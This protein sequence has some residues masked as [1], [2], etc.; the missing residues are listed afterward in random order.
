[1]LIFGK[2]GFVLAIIGLDPHGKRRNLI[3]RIITSVMLIIVIWLLLFLVILDPN[4]DIELVQAVMSPIVGFISTA[5]SYVHLLLYR[6]KFYSLLEEVKDIVH[7]SLW[8]I[9][10]SDRN[11]LIVNSL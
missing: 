1:M 4:P 9:S 5:I 2:Y 6:Q 7:E 3:G 10:W 8:N 11:L